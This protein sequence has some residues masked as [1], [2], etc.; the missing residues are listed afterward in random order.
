MIAGVSDFKAAFAGRT[1]S[2]AVTRYPRRN[3]ILAR[4]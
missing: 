2:A 1:T 4:S 3:P